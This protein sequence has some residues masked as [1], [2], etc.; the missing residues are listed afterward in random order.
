[1]LSR[2]DWYYGLRA[3]PRETSNITAAG[4]EEFLRSR[5]GIRVV[6]V[7]IAIIA[8]FGVLFPWMRGI[9]FLDPVMTAAYACL[10]VLFAAPAAAQ[11]FGM[12]RPRSLA[13]AIAC[14]LRAVAYGEM[15]T[16]LILLAGFTTLYAT[17]PFAFGPDLETMALAGAFG[18]AASLA[19]A[20][21]AGWMT[22]R[23]SAGAAQAGMRVL[24]LLLLC[25]FF[26]KAGWLPDVAG[27]AALISLAIAAAALLGL[28]RAL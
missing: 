27:R 11:W 18:I 23:L 5:I 12:E 25:L 20:T 24:F 16:V 13:R 3:E 9:G 28:S 19:T 2:M 15:M 8:V 21:I 7:H 1:M 17:R 26:F 22:L 4:R 6:L 10:G 14:I